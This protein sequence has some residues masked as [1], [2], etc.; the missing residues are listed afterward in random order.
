MRPGVEAA[1]ARGDFTSALRDLAR[2]RE[3]VDRFF[4]GV[5]VMAEDARLRQNRL[6]L[7]ASLC[8]WWTIREDNPEPGAPA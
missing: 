3:A 1:F 4:D 8:A 2:L 7:L 5:M 6:A